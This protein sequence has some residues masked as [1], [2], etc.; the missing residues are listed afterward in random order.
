MALW[1]STP[2]S[3][4]SLY[5]CMVLLIRHICT[6]N[7]KR[8]LTQNFNCK[9]RGSCAAC[10]KKCDDYFVGQTMPSSSQRWTNIMHYET[11]FVM[12]TIVI[13]RPHRLCDKHHKL[14]LLASLILFNVFRY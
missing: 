1:Q 3:N 9:D 6:L 8:R 13:I 5:S 14:F 7:R 12:L 4:H 10:R 2:C 11:D